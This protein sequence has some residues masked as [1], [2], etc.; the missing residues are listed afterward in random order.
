MDTAERPADHV[1][2]DLAVTVGA[3]PDGED[4]GPIPVATHATGVTP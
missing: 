3:T 1:R 4:R 2:H